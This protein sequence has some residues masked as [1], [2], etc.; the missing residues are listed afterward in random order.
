MAQFYA[1]SSSSAV[2]SRHLLLQI[3]DASLALV[4]TLLQHAADR[5]LL[6]VTHRWRTTPLERRAARQVAAFLDEAHGYDHAVTS[7]RCSRE[8]VVVSGL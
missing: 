7:L 1:T 8:H 3:A 2:Y 4:R 6:L 5:L